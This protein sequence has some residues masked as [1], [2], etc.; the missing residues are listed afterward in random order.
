MR[1]TIWLSGRKYV[2]S[3]D[4]DWAKNISAHYERQIEKIRIGDKIILMPPF[5]PLAG[6]RVK[7]EVDFNDLADLKMKVVSAYLEGYDVVDM[8]IK[9]PLLKQI[10]EKL[11]KFVPGTVGEP[12]SDNRRYRLFFSELFYDLSLKKM[13]VDMKEIF[14]ELNTRTRGSFEAFPDSAAIKNNELYAYEQEQR[15]DNITFY[16]RRQL[17]EVLS[18]AELYEKLGIKSE[19]E[20]IHLSS[21]FGYFERL[22][23]IHGEIIQRITKILKCNEIKAYPNLKPF[24]LYYD[25]AYETIKTSF[26]AQ[27]DPRKG[28]EVI[29]GKMSEEELWKDY[30]DGI[31]LTDEEKVKE[32][33]YSPNNPPS[34]IRHLTILEGKIQAIPGISSNICELAWN[35]YGII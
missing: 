35:R 30:R 12:T 17:N 32:V 11:H 2:T 20:A 27:D 14:N 18:Y 34:I 25:H 22:G 24:L 23:D 5:D 28:L 8:P 29:R 16:M 7:I 4:N 15:L 6:R 3:L 13:F 1:G 21:I 26:D 19:R 31:L 9:S 10:K 33:I